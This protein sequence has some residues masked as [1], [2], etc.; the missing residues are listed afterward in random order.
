MRLHRSMCL[1][2]TLGFLACAVLADPPDSDIAGTKL[3]S[4]PEISLSA[5]GPMVD[6]SDNGGHPRGA[7]ND[8]CTGATPLTIGVAVNDTTVGMNIDTVPPCAPFTPSGGGVW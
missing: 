4:R 1:A 2:P 8:D 5:V 7:G 3:K 6:P